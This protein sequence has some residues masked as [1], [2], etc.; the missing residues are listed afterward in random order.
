MPK[1]R[2]LH[3]TARLSVGGI[4]RWLIDVIKYHDSN[5]FQMDVLCV[6][7]RSDLGTMVGDAKAAGAHIS[8][9]PLTDPFFLFKY[10]RLLKH[11]K[12]DV[13]VIHL[14]LGLALPLVLGALFAGV[15]QRI[16]LVHSSKPGFYTRW[17]F[18]KPALRFFYRKKC[19]KIAG[20]SQATLDSVFPGWQSDKM[21]TPLYLGID[22]QMFH[23]TSL[24]DEVRAEIGIPPDVPVIG[25]FGRFTPAKN[26]YGFLETARYL[27]ELMPSVQFIL[28]G[29]GPLQSEI[30]N[31]AEK[32]SISK[33]VHF[34]GLRN[35]VAQLLTAIDLV[36]YPSLFEGFPVSFIE[37]Q[38]M[39]IPVVT[40]Q[41]PELREAICPEYVDLLSVDTGNPVVAAQRIHQL[42]TDHD[43][44]Q[45]VSQ[46]GQVWARQNFSIEKSTRRLE[47][48]IL[49]GMPGPSLPA[50]EVSA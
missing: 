4:E 48:I 37:A 10:Y 2:V 36:Y 11:K 38:I 21:Y 15:K 35:D 49:S 12:I 45:L 16:L 32:Y 8:Y 14:D 34:L 28:A 1:I 30:E 5:Q 50:S 39:G 22:L 23:P 24:K 6:A 43:L 40:G 18:L 25:H 9:I 41:R 33:Q 20:V 47:E 29:E 42:L 46:R 26:H 13:V 31:L 3:I 7:R 19:T 44:W 17:G 27:L